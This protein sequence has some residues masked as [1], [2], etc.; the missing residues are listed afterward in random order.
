MKST[1]RVWKIAGIEVGVHYSWFAVLALFSWVLSDQ[2]LPSDPEYAGWST[3]RYW[4]TGII[5]TLLLFV[6]VLM[7]ELAHSLVARARGFHVEGITLFILGG[8]STLRA[9][10]RGPKDEFVIS[11]VGPMTSLVLAGLF[12][13]GL[14]AIPDRTTSVAAVVWYMWVVNL[15]L[16][17]FN[18]LPAF[19]LD[20]GQV[21]RSAVWG[22]TGSLTKATRVASGGG[23]IMAVLLIAV[24]V[25]AIFRGTPWFGVWMGVIGWF[26][27][28]AATSSLRDLELQSSL[29]SILV[30]DVMVRKPETIYPEVTIG[31]VVF[32]H[33]LQNGNRALP[34]TEGDT[35][36]GIF[37]LTDAKK[38]PQ[39]RWSDVRVKDAMTPAPLWSL[40]PDDQLSHALELLAEHSLNQAPVVEEGRMMGLLTRAGIIEHLHS[41]QELRVAPRS[42]LA[43]GTGP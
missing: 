17:I 4:A 41:R 24:G 16:A 8:V 14:Q 19:P 42:D 2:V 20:G 39:Y 38:V 32:E 31:D 5:V 27:Y 12:W 28:S 34:V 43:D 1:F 13:L 18:L 25:F 3:T 29:R 21:L 26:L 7:H 35:L 30:M 40:R 37:T 22:V 9:E 6:M 33:F 23:R 36:I 15:A 10:V 11:A